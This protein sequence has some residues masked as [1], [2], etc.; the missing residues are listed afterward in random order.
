MIK[1]YIKK[2]L[3]NLD[4]YFKNKNLNRYYEVIKDINNFEKKMNNFSSK[5][6]LDKTI[7]FK[8][9]LKFNNDINKLL[10][11]AFALVKVACNKIFNINLFDTQLIGS[12]ILHEGKIAEMM[13]GEGKTISI[14]LSAYLNSLNSNVH[15]VT[16]NDYL[17]KRDSE[18][19]KDVFNLLGMTVGI[20]IPE[21]SIY[22]K[23]K[24][25]KCNIVYGTGNEYVFDYL[26]DNM[27]FDIKDK[28]QSKLDYVIIDEI[29]SILIDES[30][31]PLIISENNN[32]NIDIYIKINNLVKFFL[33]KK[34][35]KYLYIDI[36]YKN[37]TIIFNELGYRLLEKIMIKLS[38]IN[39]RYELYKDNNSTILKYMINAIKVNIFFKK[40]I[41]YLVIDKNILIIDE[42]TGRISNDRRWSNGIHQAIE[43]KENVFIK[44]E[45]KI[46]SS[47]TFNNYFN[48]YKKISGITGTASNEKDEFKYIYNLNI[49]SI[50]TNKPVIRKDYND[51]LF[52]TEDSKIEYIIK[53]IKKRLKN[54]QPILIGTTSI[55]KSELLSYFLNKNN[56]KHKILN[57]KYHKLE[58]EIISQAGK[59]KSVTISTNMAGRGTDII[60]G[61]N[62]KYILKKNN[63][64]I[65]K[66]YKLKNK[67][68]FLNSKVI[69][70]G[71]L[72]V[73]GTER[74]ESRRIDNQLIGRSGR[75]GDPGS[76]QFLISIEDDLIKRFIPENIIEII[77]N[78]SKNIDYISNSWIDK[79]IKSA[80]SK[81]EKNNFEIRK[82]LILYD[83]IF[84]IQRTTL[85][86]IR[87]NLLNDYQLNKIFNSINDEIVLNY[88]KNNITSSYSSSLDNYYNYK[89]IFNLIIYELKEIYPFIL[90]IKNIFFLKN[91][92]N[93]K[94]NLL[95]Y[96]TNFIHYYY[97]ENF[98]FKKINYIKKIILLKVLDF[99]WKY[100]IE[101][102]EY[103]K[104]NIFLRSY[105]NKDPKEEFKLESFNKFNNIINNWKKYSLIII[106]IILY[107]SKKN[108]LKQKELILKLNKYDFIINNDELFNLLNTLN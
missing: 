81:I 62:Y 82:E 28:I 24:S 53:D 6:F 1:A 56:I 58:A 94:V 64:D 72:H 69:N 11:E 47:I 7:E 8:K 60:L 65:E 48:L 52:F 66:K 90:E 68:K 10:P 78:S 35:N 103:L 32:V 75:Q 50:P 88:I 21:M 84:N 83:N 3:L 101:D 33:Y 96:I 95:K 43:A 44:N 54:Y 107:I 89:K 27:I 34:N 73:I 97:N 12:I 40:D 85:Y 20:N 63:Y 57:A 87:N 74:N 80:Q 46:L 15:I 99:F 51:L 86:K 26:K 71:G 18:N 38:F 29:D 16:M 45:N 61:G 5:D 93:L 102:I 91:I 41:D 37:K 100:H 98:N 31:I 70:S 77:K 13:T 76:S 25:Y 4:D 19:N 108:F 9:R 49:V 55:K 42:N 22:N 59:P 39:K 14:I 104:N 2:I 79:M 105:I 106:N 17:A 30:K 67:F 36:N 23:K 92:K